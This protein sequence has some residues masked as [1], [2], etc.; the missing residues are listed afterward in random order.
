MVNNLMILGPFKMPA[1]ENQP[2]RQH[3]FLIGSEATVQSGIPP[4]IVDI[5]LKS[6]LHTP[7]SIRGTDIADEPNQRF[8]EKFDPKPTAIHQKSSNLP[9]CRGHI[10]ADECFTRVKDGKS[11]GFD[12]TD[13]SYGAF[14]PD[15]SEVPDEIRA[16]YQKDDL[17]SEQ[18]YIDGRLCV[19]KVDVEYKKRKG[20]E[21][22]KAKARGAEIIEYKGNFFE[23]I[24]SHETEKYFIQETD[25]IRDIIKYSQEDPAKYEIIGLRNGIL[26]YKY[27]EGLNQ[28]FSG[29]F[30]I[31]L[32][33]LSK[34]IPEGDYWEAANDSVPG[35][36]P[37]ALTSW[38]EQNP[39]KIDY[40]AP[41]D[42][43]V[44]GVR[45]P[46]L[47][48][49]GNSGYP[50]TGDFDLM[51]IGL[52]SEVPGIFLRA[53]NT[54]ITG[55]ASMLSGLIAFNRD[56]RKCRDIITNDP[57]KNNEAFAIFQCLAKEDG[58]PDPLRKFLNGSWT[59][60]QGKMHIGAYL[61]NCSNNI[62][63]NK[64]MFQHGEESFN[65]GDSEDFGALDHMYKGEIFH[66][67]T[68]QQ[69]LDFFFHDPDYLLTQTINVHPSCLQARSDND[70]NNE[71]SMGW[72]NLIKIQILHGKENLLKPNTIAAYDKI[73]E[74]LSEIN[75]K[76][77]GN[78]VEQCR[79]ML[80]GSF[81]EYCE[82]ALSMD[83]K[84]E[85]DIIN[86]RQSTEG[87]NSN[88]NSFHE[89][90]KKSSS[91]YK[92]NQ[93]KKLKDIDPL[94]AL[95]LEVLEAINSNS[96][97]NDNPEFA[98]DEMYPQNDSAFIMDN[99]Q[100]GSATPTNNASASVGGMEE[101]H[102][103]SDGE[104]VYEGCQPT[105]ISVKNPLIKH[106]EK[107]RHIQN[108]RLAPLKKEEPH[109]IPPDKVEVHHQGH[110]EPNTTV[111]LD[112]PSDNKK[113]G[114]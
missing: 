29:T 52:P 48:Q 88:V 67:D 31:D 61:I 24:P 7:M 37:D 21:I 64:D 86:E 53:H 3:K 43:I 55:E 98:I 17:G 56:V 1:P 109:G 51:H 16:Q 97:A 114:A 30:E 78:S 69:C 4:R 70:E 32:N 34:S 102:P 111:K 85:I 45:K 5:L 100:E 39:Q 57:Y 44:N 11:K 106:N 46:V 87:I 113:P 26:Q 72:V 41:V 9:P 77:T 101:M 60:S 33:K 2:K 84:K 15:A 50:V 89:L 90:T 14:P 8:W 83:L 79:E 104:I 99:L 35:N 96:F 107:S 76:K 112:K 20:E 13:H 103:E 110:L 36:I 23:K 92:E 58:K 18:K 71:L 108:S 19:K 65:P 80:G 40:R 28:E 91:E 74:H 94:P 6:S 49:A 47:V 38:V 81:K 93:K 22:V 68:E 82:N 63:M 95:P 27:P 25:S 10:A 66:T 42:Q 73:I 54:Y 62:L 12:L 105:K 75:S 59:A